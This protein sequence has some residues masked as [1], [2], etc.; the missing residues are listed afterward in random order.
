MSVE[1]HISVVGGAR[2]GKGESIDSNDESPT[3]G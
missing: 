1:M 2:D 3:V